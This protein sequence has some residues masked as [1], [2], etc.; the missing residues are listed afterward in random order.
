[1]DALTDSSAGSLALAS[2]SNSPELQPKA[3]TTASSPA[4]ASPTAWKRCPKRK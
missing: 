2:K 4:A 1:M 3:F